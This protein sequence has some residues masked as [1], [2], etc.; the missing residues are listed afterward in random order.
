MQTES[1]FEM[2]TIAPPPPPPQKKVQA[3][4]RSGFFGFR[5]LKPV[6]SLF[7]KRLSL[8]GRPAL[9][10]SAVLLC[11]RLAASRLAG[12]RFPANPLRAS[13]PARSGPESLFNISK[14]SA[15]A[16]AAA[17]FLSPVASVGTSSAKKA[18][19]IQS[20]LKKTEKQKRFLLLSATQTAIKTAGGCY[21]Q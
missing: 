6:A 16:G 11:A 20:A 5:P 10:K 1:F 17:L 4:V 7:K 9:A 21:G 12:S 8:C 13:R 14:R 15:F 2:K 3:Q 18:R 19:K